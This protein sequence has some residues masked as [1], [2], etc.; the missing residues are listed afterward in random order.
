[1]NNSIKTLFMNRKIVLLISLFISTVASVHAQF[2]PPNIDFEAASLTNWNCFRGTNSNAGGAFSACTTPQFNFTACAPVPTLHTLETGPGLDYYGGFPVVAPGG[3]SYSMKIGKDTNLYNADGVVYWVHVP[4]GSTIYSLVYHFAAVLE[5]PTGHCYDDQPRM[6]AEAFDSTGG[7]DLPCDSFCY[8]GDG[9][10]PGFVTSAVPSTIPGNGADVHYKPWTTGN[11]KFNGENGKTVGIR[12]AAGGCTQSG[13]FGYGYIDMS[14]GLFAISTIACGTAGITLSAPPGYAGYRWT[15]SLTFGIT[16]GTLQIQTAPTPPVPTTY[17]VILTPY[18]GY[19]CSDTLYTRVIPANLI[20]IP[21]PDTSICAGSSL[22]LTAGASD[23]PSGLP[24]TYSWSPGASLSCTG[25]ANPVATPTVSTTY[26]VTVNDAVGCSQTDFI[27]VTVYPNP[28]GIT[29]TAVVCAGGGTTTLSDATPGGHW[30]SSNP[31][32]ASIGST[33]GFVTGGAAPGPGPSTVTMTYSFGPLNICGV[34]IVVTVNPMPPVIVGPSNICQGSTALFTDPSGGGTWSS[35]STL[36]ATIGSASGI[37]GGVAVGTTTISY[38]FTSTGCSRLA[39][40]NVVSL[41]GPISAPAFVCVG[42]TTTLIDAST[43][44]GTWT[45]TNPSLATIGSATGTIGGILPGFDT[46]IYTL[47]SG[48]TKS[49]TIS[50]NPSPAAITGPLSVCV[51]NNVTLFDATPGGVWSTGTPS[52]ATVLDPATGLFQGLSP[53]S[54]L[55]SYTV[56]GCSAVR[57][58]TVNP[59]P[60]PIFAADPS[61]CS[62]QS[63][64]L[65]DG[66]PGGTWSSA[67]PTIATVGSISG[68]VGGVITTGGATTVSYILPTGCSALFGITVAPLPDSITGVKHVCMGGMTTL[69]ETTIGGDWSTGDP[70]IA[71][72]DAAGNVYGI[73]PGTVS[74][75]YTSVPMGC[76]RCTIVTVNPAPTSIIGPTTICVGSFDTLVDATPGGTWSPSTGLIATVGSG[77]GVVTG[78]GSGIRTITYTAPSGCYTTVDM[79]V[80]PVPAVISGVSNRVCVGSTITLNDATTGGTWTS[81]N[82]SIATAGSS[83]SATTCIVGGVAPGVVTISYRL[84]TG[85]ARTFVVTVNSTP[86]APGGNVPICAG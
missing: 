50:V 59:N 78:V 10:V 75:C 65:F 18:T 61:V 82:T 56:G 19:G 15:D 74:I 58:L 22:T 76:I 14:C 62:G 28:V 16:Y 40:L 66:T 29:G 36:I 60:G 1:V 84:S 33:T 69:F 72:V 25:C 8:V 83:G 26:T 41:P 6:T 3:G 17:A 2:C 55:I 48:C 54:S 64:L 42:A 44:G 85:C 70:T 77:T 79:L 4:A 30:I 21:T 38:T 73:L 20:V 46:I 53:V 5:Q 57:P 68:F 45:S 52:V 81:S 86:G 9:S 67:D 24:L 43:P 47:S 11:F 34:S 39:T 7:H 13:H 35:L 49:I 51:G 32:I 71:T 31:S 63:E 23:V 80:F 12:F 27:H 37:A